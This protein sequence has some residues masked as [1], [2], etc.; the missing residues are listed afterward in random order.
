LSGANRSGACY[1]IIYDWRKRHCRAADYLDFIVTYITRATIQNEPIDVAD[2]VV[3][4]FEQ[5]WL[6]GAG[7]LQVNG[8]A[9]ALPVNTGLKTHV[10]ALGAVTWNYPDCYTGCSCKERKPLV[11]V[12]NILVATRE[13][14][15]TVV[16]V[17]GVTIPIQICTKKWRLLTGIACIREPGWWTGLGNS[18]LYGDESKENE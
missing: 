4:G 10:V 5:E 12:Q 1:G 7:A 2:Y 14:L 8:I 17:D 13:V 3:T 9:H 6:G 15:L 18:N 16:V 11:I